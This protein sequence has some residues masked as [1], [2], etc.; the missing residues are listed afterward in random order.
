MM[1]FE[2]K[3]LYNLLRMNWLRD[4]SIEVEPWQVEN[5]R[6]LSLETLFDRLEDFNVSMDRLSFLSYAS[7][8]DSPEALCEDLCD[9][10]TEVEVYDQ[11]YLIVFELWRRLLPEATS[12]SIFCDELDHQIDLYDTEESA[13]PDDMQDA[14]ANLLNILDENADEGGPAQEIFARI[15]AGCANELES[16]LYDYIAELIDNEDFTY[17]GELIEGF[18][19]YVRDRSWFDF[20]RARLL[21]VTDMNA[22]NRI[23]KALLQDL[24]KEPDL[25]LLME[26]LSF[27]VQGGE[28]K[29]FMKVVHAVEG[30]METEE[31]FQELLHTCADFHRCLDHDY[32]ERAI[33]EILSSRSE[34]DPQEPL[35]ERD[36]DRI[37]LM[38]I[39]ELSYPP[40]SGV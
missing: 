27:M 12:L 5:Y 6:I 38:R 10:D 32:Q 23:V 11:L 34:I 25:D 14:L 9:E 33:E 20:L 39:L 19:P 4:R 16:F 24:L 8:F 18:Y 22:A 1:Q 28:P 21:A 13:H 15:A 31:E 36:P 17:A 2:K 40:P 7:D 35:D 3:A 26:I 29:L 37:S 30:L